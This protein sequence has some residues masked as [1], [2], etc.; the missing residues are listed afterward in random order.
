MLCDAHTRTR[1]E[2][3]GSGGNVERRNRSSAGSARIHELVGIIRIQLY[4]R[5][6][7]SA[8][9]T[10]DDLG[11]FSAD[12]E[13]G[14]QSRNLKLGGFSAHDHIERVGGILSANGLVMGKLDDY[15]VE[16]RWSGRPGHRRW[17]LRPRT[18]RGAD[19]SQR[20]VR[21]FA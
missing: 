1:G 14:E 6:P 2:Q 5:F 18:E 9:D 7:K 11:S 19:P 15:R 8:N 4:H 13:P 12:T 16:R 17:W 3:C 21:I 10:R 20:L